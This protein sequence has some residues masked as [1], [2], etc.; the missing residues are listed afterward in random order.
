[1]S[2]AIF[3]DTS[4]ILA[5]LNSRDKF[6][7]QARAAATTLLPPFIT[8]EAVLIELGNALAK[9]TWRPLALLRWLNCEARPRLK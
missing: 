9:A 8:T 4:Y 7:A 2:S 3:L 1:M 6:H 5:A